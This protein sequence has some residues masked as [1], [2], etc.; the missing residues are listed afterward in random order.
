MTKFSLDR[1]AVAHPTQGDGTDAKGRIGFDSP[2]YGIRL[3]R[4]TRDEALEHMVHHLHLAHVYYQA[5]P[6]DEAA[7][8]AEVE[9]LLD[10]ETGRDGPEVICARAFLA[11]ANAYYAKLKQEQDE[12]DR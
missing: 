12:E 6:E 1:P 7:V 9:R 5:T 8:K 11:A 4:A 10:D 3:R 2:L